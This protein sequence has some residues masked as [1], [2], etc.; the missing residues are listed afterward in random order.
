MN[1]DLLASLHA[2]QNNE[3]PNTSI[4]NS[5]NTTGLSTA[6]GNSG[7]TIGLSTSSRIDTKNWGLEIK[8]FGLQTVTEGALIQPDSENLNEGD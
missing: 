4:G 2:L 1:E 6:I 5:G 3:K 8:E 7:N